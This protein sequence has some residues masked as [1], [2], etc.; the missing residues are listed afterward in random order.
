MTSPYKVWPGLQSHP[1]GEAA[2]ALR[3]QYEALKKPPTRLSPLIAMSDPERTPDI[4]SW[5]K[6]LPEHCAVIYRFHKFDKGL[7]KNLRALTKK[8]HQQLLTR[9]TLIDTHP[10]SSCDGHHFIRNTDLAVLSK[11]A[12]LYPEKLLTL[13]ALKEGHYQSPLPPLDGLFV[14]STFPSQSPSAGEPIGV[15]T[16]RKKAESLDAPVFALGGVTLET[17]KQLTQTKIAGIACVGALNSQIEKSLI[18]EQKVKFMDKLKIS[19]TITD[20]TIQFVATLADVSDKAVLDMRL[21]SKGV[22]N[23]Y[24]TGVPKSMGGKGVGTALVKTMVEDASIEGYKIHPGCPFVAIWFKRKPEWA[25]MAAEN[26][27]LYKR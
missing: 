11:F 19:K 15:D 24:H 10:D 2:L 8:R 20:D 7:A 12:A 21:M 13:A 16:L 22:Y 1:L 14:S 5:A 3:V 27:A 18:K 9:Q 17:V 23:A 4:L 25:E 6:S 26:P